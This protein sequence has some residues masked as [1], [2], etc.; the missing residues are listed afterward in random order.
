MLVKEIICNVYRIIHTFFSTSTFNGIK[1]SDH[2]VAK[3]V[4]MTVNYKTKLNHSS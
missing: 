3:N 4:I 2:N 1:N